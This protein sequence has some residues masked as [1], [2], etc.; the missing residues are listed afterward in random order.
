MAVILTLVLRMYS[1]F[2][3]YL[4][5]CS[6]EEDQIHYGATL[7]IAC[8]IPT[9]SCLLMPWRLKEPGH[10]Q[11]WYWPRKLEYST[12]SIRRVKLITFRLIS[13]VGNLRISCEFTPRWMPQS[14]CQH[15]M[16]WCFRA[17]SHYLSGHWPRFMSR[18]G[19]TRPQWVNN[20]VW[21]H[22]LLFSFR[23]L[24][25]ILVKHFC[26]NLICQPL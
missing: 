8:P 21:R 18:Y 1:H 3:T 7:D 19:V 2:L 25:N 20:H 9:I 16:A 4:G 17:P 15:L 26:I 14:T 6:P 22:W 5:F 10:Q 12:S 13:R 24:P 11:A 23:C